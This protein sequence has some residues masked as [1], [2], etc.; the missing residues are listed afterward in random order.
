MN[1]TE[2]EVHVMD[3]LWHRSP[4]STEDIA[5]ALQGRQAWKRATIKTLINRL[6][7]KGAISATPDGRRYLYRPV[8]QHQDWMAEQRNGL[9]D[10]WFDGRLTPLVTHF[11]AH[12]KLRRA[13]I[14][15]LKRLIKEYDGA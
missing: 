11:A 3:V 1:I 8:L 7:N 12:R 4:M 9:L 2:A 6:L 5:Q 10:R 15:A 13:D 14:E